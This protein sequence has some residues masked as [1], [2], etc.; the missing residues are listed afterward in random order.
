MKLCG[1]VGKEG[2]LENLNK[3]FYYGFKKRNYLSI[4]KLSSVGQKPPKYLEEK[5][6]EM[7]GRA[8]EKIKPMM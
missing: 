2:Y 5:M 7:K 4:R 8:R 3:W 6:I 1:G